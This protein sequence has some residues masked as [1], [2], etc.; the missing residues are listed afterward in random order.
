MTEVSLGMAVL[1]GLLSFAS[2]CVLPLVPAFLGHL[3]GAAVATATASAPARRVVFLHALAFV[4][5]FAA[6]YTLLGASVGLIG[7]VLVDQLPLIRKAGGVLLVLF[8]LHTIGI[9]QIPLLYRE[10]KVEAPTRREWGYLSSALVGMVFAAGW[11]PCVGVILAGIL[12][13]ASASQT[14]GKGAALLLAYSLGLGI[15]FLITGLALDRLTPF[16]RQLNRRQR[17]VSIASGLLLI[18]M[19][20]LIFTDFFTRLAAYS[21]P[22]WRQIEAAVGL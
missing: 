15:P 2:P 21:A 9:V 22:L 8:G 16:L 5:G 1:A 12:L 13:L 7:Y 11:T 14:V 3:S 6:I 17:L 20:I 10:F 18:T 4:L 19:G